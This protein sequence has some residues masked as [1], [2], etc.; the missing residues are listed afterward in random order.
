MG[1]RIAA[2]LIFTLALL[3]GFAPVCAVA[4]AAVGP[5]AAPTSTVQVRPLPSA[6]RKQPAAPVAFDAERATNAYLARINGAAR[7]RSDSYFEG[8]YVLQIVDALYAVAIMAL[9][10]WLRI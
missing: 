6:T 8:G 3:V 2:F 1:Y 5:A 7:A 4:Q 9:L 10:L